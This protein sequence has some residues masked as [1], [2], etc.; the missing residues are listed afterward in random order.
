M[1]GQDSNQSDRNPPLLTLKH[2]ISIVSLKHLPRFAAGKLRPEEVTDSEEQSFGVMRSLVSSQ[3]SFPDGAGSS[4]GP[5]L[6]GRAEAAWAVASS[7]Q[8]YHGKQQFPQED[9]STQSGQQG[10]AT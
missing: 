10:Q 1:V 5:W 8:S 3:Y 7:D 9:Q 2:L 6:E 4:W